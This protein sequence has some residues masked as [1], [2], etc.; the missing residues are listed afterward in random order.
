MGAPST[1]GA[2]VEYVAYP[3]AFTYRLPVELSFEDGALLE[4]LSVGL[5][6]VDRAGV[7]VGARVL[8][9]GAGPIGLMTMLAARAC[10]A[11]RVY[12]TDIKPH[13]LELARRLGAD[14]VVDV[15]LERTVQGIAELT[16]GE[17]VDVAL[18]CSAS[19]AAIADC[20]ASVKRGGT[21][22]LVGSGLDKCLLPASE[23]VDRE[24]T[25]KGTFRY[26]NTYPRALELVSSGR[27]KLKPL[28]THRFPLAQIEEAL[29][30]AAE[31]REGAVK[32]V[33]SM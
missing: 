12:M 5:H 24:L 9:T 10:G 14:G 1:D 26:A 27:V 23:M 11:A 7:G 19:P 8:I 32:V 16:G 18:D 17:G 25:V 21:V 20:L 4:P 30:L 13:R 3:A 33:I 22:V 2:F 28:V 15:Q 6:A 31:G 29:E